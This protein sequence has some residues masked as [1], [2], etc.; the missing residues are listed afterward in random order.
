MENT[1][2]GMNDNG[3][4]TGCTSIR[5][6]TSTFMKAPGII[7]ALPET[8]KH[9]AFTELHR[10]GVQ[11]EDTIYDNPSLSAARLGHNEG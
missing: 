7:N 11:P 8:L 5:I 4:K 3:K 10:Q 2:F 6:S 1:T 9:C